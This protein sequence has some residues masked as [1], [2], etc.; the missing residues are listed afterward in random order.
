M[1]ISIIIPC[2][3]NEKSI[4]ELMRLMELVECHDV[5]ESHNFEYIFVDD[6]S[7][8]NTFLRQTGLK[9]EL[10][11]DIKIVKLTRNFGSYN[12]LLAGMYYATGDCNVYLHADLQ[13]P[14]ELIPELFKQYLIG[15]K[16]VIAN[17]T[18]R[19]DGSIFSALYHWMVRR[20]AVKNVPTGGFDLILFDKKI[21][22]DIV[23][24]SEK[25]TNNIYLISWLGYPYVSI[26]YVRQSR[27]Y[28]VSQ[29]TLTKKVRLFVDTFFSFSDIPITII[30]TVFLS[31]LIFGIVVLVLLLLGLAKHYLLLLGIAA[32][33][34]FMI[35]LNF[36]IIGEFLIR[37]HE[38]VRK[39]PNFVVEKVV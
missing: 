5:F 2:Y 35:S 3:N 31:S 19:E 4:N 25:N 23:E 24:I 27:K 30:R 8:D 20:Y 26:P 13:D 7:N 1:K 17:R 33:L 38:T 39:R 11:K 10:Q 16:L 14:P 32:F 18:E 36:L 22:D 28:G 34:Y 9:V 29:W 6:G 37:I 21:K 15:N 12:S